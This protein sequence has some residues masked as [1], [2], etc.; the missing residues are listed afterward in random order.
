MVQVVAEKGYVATTVAD[1]VER[2]GVSRRTF[3]EQFKSKED[4]FLAGYDAGVEVMLTRMGAAAATAGISEDDWRARLRSD[5]TAYMQ[6]LAEEPAFAWSLHVEVL[7]AGSE[8]LKR[9]A[10]VFAVFSE[11]TRQ[12]Y[13]NARAEDPQLPEL[14]GEAFAVHTGGLDEVIREC[15]R[16]RGPDALSGLV[17]PAVATTMALFGQRSLS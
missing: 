11:R 3:Y 7:A 12:G 13:E 2:A 6:L 15:L 17:D 5:L 8:A 10:R 4:C 16:T 9:R 1:I 14:P